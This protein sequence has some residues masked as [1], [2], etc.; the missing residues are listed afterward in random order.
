MKVIVAAFNQ[1]K[2]LV[3]SRRD[4]TSSNIRWQQP[5][6][7]VSA[8]V[9]VSQQEPEDTYRDHIWC[10]RS[11]SLSG[12]HTASTARGPPRSPAQS[13]SSDTNLTHEVEIILYRAVN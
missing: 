11:G 13:S 10:S 7:I 1:E 2:A 5:C 8:D 6:G 4:Y 3:P 12:D 9:N